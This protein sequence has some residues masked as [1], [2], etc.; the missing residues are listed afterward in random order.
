MQAEGSIYCKIYLMLFIFESK[1]YAYL[2]YNISVA[3]KAESVINK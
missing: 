1:I 3:S 2:L